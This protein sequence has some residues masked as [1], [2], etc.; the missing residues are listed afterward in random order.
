MITS[1]NKGSSMLNALLTIG[2]VFNTIY[3]AEG[4]DV[5]CRSSGS[6]YM[7]GTSAEVNFFNA[8]GKNFKPVRLSLHL[9]LPFPLL[10]FHIVVEYVGSH[11]PIVSHPTFEHYSRHY[12]NRLVLVFQFG[13][14]P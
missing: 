10:P 14:S 1:N 4:A 7:K 6:S 11:I 8:F 12:S 3:G 13:S 2:F 9:A 5:E